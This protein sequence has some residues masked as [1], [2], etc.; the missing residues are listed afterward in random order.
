M[1][2]FLLSVGLTLGS[3][4]LS[5]QMTMSLTS[6]ASRGPVGLP[7][8]WNAQVDGIDHGDSSSDTIWYRYRARRLDQGFKIIRDFGPRTDLVWSA[9]E[10]EGA[11][12]LEVTAR[13]LVSG[14]AVTQTSLF[15][16][17]PLA[18]DKPVITSTHPLV[19]LDSAP[20][21]AAGSRIRVLLR[22]P[23]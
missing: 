13:D 7:V 20:P 16:A 5:A 12:E 22:D 18:V 2:P 8:V 21:W 1:K 23:N 11:Y 17:T 19:F 6:T 3:T 15:D 9:T 10:H 4:S 14:E